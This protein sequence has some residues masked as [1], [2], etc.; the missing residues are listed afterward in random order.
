MEHKLNYYDAGHPLLNKITHVEHS[1]AVL[2]YDVA[3]RATFDEL[4]RW[5]E[6]AANF[7]AGGIP[8]A[9]CGNKVRIN[10]EITT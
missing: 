2:V 6:E 8:V 7:G 3:N 10:H 9:V 4:E 5:L 1:Q